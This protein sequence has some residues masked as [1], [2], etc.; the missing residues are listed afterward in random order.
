MA[1]ENVIGRCKCPVCGS[2]RASLRVSAKQLAYV[3]SNC[4][5]SQTF[6]RSD[7]SDAHL[8]ALLVK[9]EPAA[10]VAA[11]EPE[12]PPAVATVPPAH[13]KPALAQPDA[14]PVQAPP[15][16]EGTGWGIFR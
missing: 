11:Q 7:E 13:K 14:A 9:A 3:V 15:K 1:G 4:C 6:A 8:R 2:T 10:P 5:N 16:P 12:K